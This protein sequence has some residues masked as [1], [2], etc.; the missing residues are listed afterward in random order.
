MN[1]VVFISC[2]ASLLYQILLEALYTKANSGSLEAYQL[3]SAWKI[4]E[5]DFFSSLSTLILH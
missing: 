1:G 4:L 2:F 3:S 5:K